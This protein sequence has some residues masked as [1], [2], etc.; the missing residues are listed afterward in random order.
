MDDYEYQKLDQEF[1]GLPHN[2]FYGQRKPFICGRC[3][4]LSSRPHVDEEFYWCERCYCDYN[5]YVR[6]RSWRLNGR[7]TGI[8]VRSV[9]HTGLQNPEI[10]KK[11]FW[12]EFFS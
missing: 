5:R 8:E 10:K 6:A 12:D 7:P 3:N 9:Q 2:I 4:N 11:G 1:S